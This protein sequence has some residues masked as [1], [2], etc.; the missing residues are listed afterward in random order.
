MIGNVVSSDDRD[1]GLYD[2]VIFPVDEFWSNGI[3][4]ISW[5]RT[6]MSL[7][8]TMLSIFVM[9]SQWRTSGINAW[10]RISLTPAISSVDLKY[11]SAESPPRFRKL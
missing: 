4:V 10:N 5:E 7:I 8:D 2:G 1:T 11:R 9:P 3:Y 6:Y